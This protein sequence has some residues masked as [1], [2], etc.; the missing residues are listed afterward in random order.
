MGFAP[1]V[2][3]PHSGSAGMPPPCRAVQASNPV[4]ARQRRG[5]R[6]GRHNSSDNTRW[7]F[8]DTIFKASSLAGALTPAPLRLRESGNQAILEREPKCKYRR[9]KPYQQRM[10]QPQCVAFSPN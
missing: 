10:T 9:D 5:S 7:H 4:R 6:E 8:P 3:A 2:A 1:F